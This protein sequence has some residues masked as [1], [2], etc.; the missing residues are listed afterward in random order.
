MRRGN[1]N[2]IRSLIALACVGGCFVAAAYARTRP[3]APGASGGDRAASIP[4]PPK[5]TIVRHPRARSVSATAKFTFSDRL[6]GARFLCRLDDSGWRSCRSPAVF[7]R[8]ATGSHAFSVRALNGRSASSATARFRWTRLE[9]KDFSIDPDLSGL[10][11]L[12][13]GA[14]PAP[15]PLTVSNPNDAP[16]LVVGLRVSVA[17]NPSG[18]PGADNLALGQSSAS[19]STPLKVPAR[20][21]AHVPTA[22]V[23]APTIQLRDLPFDQDACQGTR[24]PL[25]FTGSARG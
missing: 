2:G 6:P 23:S 9:P 20:G 24:F 1:R 17:A 16:I 21:S 22:R 3:L 14:P 5:P 11:A 13:P 15:L 12:Y 19:P 25:E 4:R 18:C 8:L 10:G 7:A